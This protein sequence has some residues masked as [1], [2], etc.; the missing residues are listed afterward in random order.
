MYY[1]SGISSL[2]GA[3][4]NGWGSGERAP[5]VCI[6]AQEPSGESVDS[7]GSGVRV[8]MSGMSGGSAGNRAGPDLLTTI[9]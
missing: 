5:P 7:G 8:D 9:P 4:F 3:P 2:S 1:I 6:T